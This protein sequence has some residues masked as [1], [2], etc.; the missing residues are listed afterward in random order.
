MAA[1]DPERPCLVLLPVC[2]FLLASFEGEGVSKPPLSDLTPADYFF[3]KFSD[4]TYFQSSSW[5]VSRKLSELAGPWW[6]L[7]SPDDDGE[8][9]CRVVAA[10]QGIHF[11]PEARCYWRVGDNR[12]FSGAWRRS[13]ASLQA[14]FLSIVRSVAHYRKLEDSERSRAACVAFLQKRLIYFYPDN[15][16]LVQQIS[17]LAEELGGAIS[18]PTL[19]WKYR[20]IE[21]AFGWPAAKRSMFVFSKHKQAVYRLW[22]HLMYD[23]ERVAVRFS[24]VGFD[25]PFA[26]TNSVVWAAAD[27]AHM[28]PNSLYLTQQPDFFDAGSGYAWPWVVPPGLP[29]ILTVAASA[30]D[31]QPRRATTLG[32]RLPN[33]EPPMG[34]RDRRRLRGATPP[35]PIAH[36]RNQSDDGRPWQN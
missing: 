27:T 1:K 32:C 12:S 22:D 3:I 19:K 21:A 26:L 34:D 16:D 35:K 36:T 4:D 33:L 2:D 23:F 5:L 30:A 10:S 24:R 20:Y 17:A 15:P 13:D 29:Q 7:R 11:V 9:F 31:C 18:P 28:L 8:Y 14:L 25:V 6:E